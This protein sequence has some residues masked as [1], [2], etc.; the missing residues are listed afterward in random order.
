MNLCVCVCVCV[1]GAHALAKSTSRE[2]VL[3]WLRLH[4]ERRR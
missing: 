4:E 2:Y 1:Y 3:R